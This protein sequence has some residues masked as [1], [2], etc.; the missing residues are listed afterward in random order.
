R[1]AVGRR[2]EARVAEAAETALGHDQLLAV[3]R[4]IGDLHVVAGVV[5]LEDLRADRHVERDVGAALAGPVGAFAVAAAAGLEDFLEPEIEERIEVGVGDEI[6]A[7][8]VT[9]VA[10][11]GTAARDELLA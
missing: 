5:L 11:V 8:A 3:A 10:A 1:R 6:D 9:A 7:A 2:R 4:Q